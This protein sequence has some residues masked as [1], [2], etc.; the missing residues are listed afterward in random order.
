MTLALEL[1]GL[2]KRY[3]DVCA[4]DD[5]SLRVASGCIFGFMGHNGAGK[6]TTIQMLLGLIRADAGEARILGLDMRRDSLAIRARCGYLPANVRLPRDMT[7][8][9]F[10]RYIAAMFGIEGQE[11]EARMAE[12]FER[13]GL[14]K[15]A[16]KKL[17]GFSTGMAQKVGLAQALINKP[18]L[19]FL[20]EPTSGLDP[21]GRH[22][23]LVYLDELAQQG[24][25]IVF[26]THILSDIES[27]C[28]QVAILHA[29]RLLAEGGLTALK[30]R[31]GCERMDDLYLQLVRS[32]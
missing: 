28:R 32:A 30:Q 10:L 17:G 6:T 31:H 14:T 16:G 13:F 26:S 3:A 27:I 1:Q 15:V 24:T 25:T 11:V 9:A 8:E 7:A 18:E 20:D 4:V 19:L 21:L 12:L 22:E 5:L 2:T 29:G 23:L